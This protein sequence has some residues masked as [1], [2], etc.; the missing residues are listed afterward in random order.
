MSMGTHMSAQAKE[1]AQCEVSHRLESFT[2]DRPTDRRVVNAS[3]RSDARVASG[4]LR[5]V[6]RLLDVQENWSERDVM[7]RGR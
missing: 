5:N 4:R 6:M 2:L 3:E 1:G 7:D